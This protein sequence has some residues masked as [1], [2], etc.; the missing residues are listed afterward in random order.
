MYTKPITWKCTILR[1]DSH[2]FAVLDKPYYPAWECTI[3]WLFQNTRVG[4]KDW[5]CERPAVDGQGIHS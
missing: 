1:L 2:D 4:Q 5:A 3:T